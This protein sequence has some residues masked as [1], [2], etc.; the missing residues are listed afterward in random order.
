MK[1]LKAIG[2]MVVMVFK[3]DAYKSGYLVGQKKVLNSMKRYIDRQ[4]KQIKKNE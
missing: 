1:L 2:E 4:W 3:I